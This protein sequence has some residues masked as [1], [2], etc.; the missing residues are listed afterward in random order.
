M[1]W[2]HL[3]PQQ[4]LGGR[5]IAPSGYTSA[6]SCEEWTRILSWINNQFGNK[7]WV[8]ILLTF[9]ERSWLAIEFC[10]PWWI[11]APSVLAVCLSSQ[12][13]P[14]QKI[15][16]GYLFVKWRQ[17]GNRTL[18]SPLSPPWAWGRLCSC[19][20]RSSPRAQRPELTGCPP[21]SP[22]P[23][24]PRGSSG[25]RRSHRSSPGS[26]QIL[27]RSGMRCCPGEPRSKINPMDGKLASLTVCFNSSNK[28]YYAVSI[29]CWKVVFLLFFL[30]IMAA[31]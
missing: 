20:G 5:G 6:W 12:A 7:H 24:P 23:S 31:D 25:T 17:P 27:L 10:S 1:H 29:C 21:S 15:V 9:I 18:A 19:W 30:V 11:L 14:V 26:R 4:L 8:E 22:P 13:P 2:W 3:P 16:F 28:D